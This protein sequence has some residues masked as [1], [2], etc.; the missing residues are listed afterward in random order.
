LY[1]RTAGT[2]FDI[3]ERVTLSE[4]YLELLKFSARCPRPPHEV[5][6]FGLNLLEYKPS[7]VVADVADEILYELEGRL[8]REYAAL[9]PLP[10]LHAA[11]LPLRTRLALSVRDVM[12]DPRTQE[13]YEPVVDLSRV[14]GDTTLRE[15]FRPGQ[16]PED[17]VG[18]WSA[19]V[20]K[21]V[22]SAIRRSER[23]I[24]REWLRGEADPGATPSSS[25]GS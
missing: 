22:L 4:A 24:L 2:G 8:E 19:S 5:I 15:Y 14:T 23:G 25:G 7:E 13:K 11:L 18:R 1:E 16:T 21:A 20:K 10:V 17:E 9:A 3:E 6:G 12:D